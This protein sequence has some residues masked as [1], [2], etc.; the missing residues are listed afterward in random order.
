MAPNND[1]PQT[2]SNSG[3]FTQPSEG[4][5]RQGLRKGWAGAL[6]MYKILIPVSF[7]TFLLEAGHI[8]DHLDGLLAPAMGLLHLPAKAAMPIAAGMLTGIYGGIAAM[9]VLTFTVKETTLIAIF[10]LIS[11]ALVQESAIQ[12]KSGLHPFKAT[13]FR[14]TTSVVV[15][16]LVGFFW[17]G[18]GHQAAQAVIGTAE[19]GFWSALQGWFWKT[20]L[21][22]GQILAIIIVI[23]TAVVWM[24]TIRLDQ[25]IASNLKPLLKLMGLSERAGLLWLTA[26]MFGISYGAAVIVEEVRGGTLSKDELERLHLSIGI[27]HAMI[28]DPAL[29]L[30]LGVSPLWLW[31]PRIA[32]AF[33]AVHLLGA[34]HAVR[35]RRQRGKIDQAEHTGTL[36]RN[37]DGASRIA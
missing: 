14:L 8:L 37:R 35:N 26:V 9:A 34:Y 28:E 24:K 2:S 4:I 17:Q 12:G 20:L 33:A 30:P 18:G 32:A 6:W 23:M 16:W 29:F 27:N 11:H 5:F 10:L 19:T 7:L 21:L 36:R 3:R 22:S 31:L 25:R 13:V 1:Q 15:V